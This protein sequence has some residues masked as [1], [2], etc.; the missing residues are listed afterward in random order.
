MKLLDSTVINSYSE[1]KVVQCI[2]I[3]LLCVQEDP[4][5]RPAMKTIVLM[6]DSD[7][8]VTLPKPEKPTFYNRAAQ[9]KIDSCKSSSISVSIEE[10]SPR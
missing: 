5:D 10:G 4:N 3:G 1:E 2:H 9:E 6:L 8:S 7:D